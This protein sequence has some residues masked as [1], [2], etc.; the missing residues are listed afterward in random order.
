MPKIGLNIG[1]GQR[2]F[3][4][5]DGVQWWNIDS[6]A[7]WNPD[8]CCNGSLLV[9]PQGLRLPQ[10]Y[11]DYV[12]LHHVLEHFGCGESSGLIAEAKRVLKP[13]GS[14]YVSVPDMKQLAIGWNAGKISTQIYFTNVYGAYMGSE[15]DRHKWGFT[16]ESL[17]LFLNNFDWSVIRYLPPIYPSGAEIARDWWILEMECV[18]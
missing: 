15:D 18:K 3:K 4:S 17:G 13:G 1:S 7:R 9:D 10:D 6:Q 14:L 11:V 5:T 16:A 2:P 12:V 8:I